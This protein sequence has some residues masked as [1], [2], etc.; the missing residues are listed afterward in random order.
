MKRNKIIILSVAS[1]LVI[2]VVA[3]VL[4]RRR[5]RKVYLK[6]EYRLNEDEY[7]YVFDRN[8]GNRKFFKGT[9]D[10]VV[11]PY[12]YEKLSFEADD[13]IKHVMYPV[14]A[15]GWLQPNGRIEKIN[16]KEYTYIDRGYLSL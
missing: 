10:Y 9:L 1:L 7:I 8:L 11:L 14:K 6:P 16:L 12:N 13:G 2:V 15:Y 5:G 3:I 4:I